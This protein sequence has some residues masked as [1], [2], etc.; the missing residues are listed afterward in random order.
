MTQSWLIKHVAYLMAC[1]EFQYFKA[2]Q[3]QILQDKK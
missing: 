3:K 1:I 2:R